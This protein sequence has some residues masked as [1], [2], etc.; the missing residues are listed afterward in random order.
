[1]LQLWSIGKGF[2]SFFHSIR[3]Y[4]LTP[5]L[6]Q[7]NFLTS[8]TYM[9][10]SLPDDDSLDGRLAPGAGEIGAPKNL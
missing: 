3:H 8:R 4:S 5:T 10:T 6:Q 1:M 7:L 9:R 2:Q